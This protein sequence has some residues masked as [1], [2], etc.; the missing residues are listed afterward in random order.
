[1]RVVDDELTPTKTPQTIF[2]L[3]DKSPVPEYLGHSSSTPICSSE[4]CDVSVSHPVL[5]ASLGIINQRAISDSPSQ[6]VAHPMS[7]MMTPINMW[8]KF[9]GPLSETVRNL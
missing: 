5:K 8:M 4:R 1:M 2:Q 9:E 6:T 3:E 7:M